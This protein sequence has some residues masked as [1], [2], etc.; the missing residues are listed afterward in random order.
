MSLAAAFHD[1]RFHPV[2]RDEL[3][4]LKLE[5]SVLSP[6]REIVDVNEIEVG[7][8]GLYIVKGVFSGLLLP[9]VATE[10]RWDRT[11]FLRETCRKAG[12]PPQAWKDEDVRI[13]VFSAEVFGE[14]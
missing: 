4:D 2:N 11:T 12:L 7:R 8:H 14:T 13:F 3:K 1:P 9:Q 10:Y 5:I 6:L